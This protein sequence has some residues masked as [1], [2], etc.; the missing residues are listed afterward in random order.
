MNY[1]TT[2]HST[3]FKYVNPESVQSE[4]MKFLYENDFIT[5]GSKLNILGK[6]FAMFDRKFLEKL[7]NFDQVRHRLRLLD[8]AILYVNIDDEELPTLQKCMDRSGLYSESG[9]VAHTAVEDCI[10]TL[11]LT[12]YKI[13]PR[14]E[15]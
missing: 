15:S 7:I 14:T 1:F 2:D 10:D 5:E 11:K 9:K 3:D 4:L 12:L 13:S 6:N 8:P